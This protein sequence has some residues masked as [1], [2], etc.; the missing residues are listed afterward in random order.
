MKAILKTPLLTIELEG[1]SQTELFTNVAKTQEIFAEP[2]CGKCKSA[3]IQFRKR[4][5]NGDDYYEMVCLDCTATLSFG[6]SKKE[7]GFLFP[8]RKLTPEGKPNRLQGVYD[9]KH[10]GWTNYRGDK[11]LD[12]RDD[13]HDEDDG[14]TKP[15]PQ[16]GYRK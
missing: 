8:I 7:K 13:T 5:V 2:G 12:A 3:N 6:Q 14:D 11:A 15:A 9:K 1:N 4:T 10:R 16:K